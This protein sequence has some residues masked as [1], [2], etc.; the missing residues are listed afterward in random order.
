MTGEPTRNQEPRARVSKAETC[1][2]G[3]LFLTE[4][5]DPAM[6]LLRV[7][8]LQDSPENVG[9][10]RPPPQE[11]HYLAGAGRPEVA[12][13]RSQAGSWT[14]RTLRSGWG[15]PGHPPGHWQTGTSRLWAQAARSQC[16]RGVTEQG[17]LGGPSPRPGPEGPPRPARLLLATAAASVPHVG[18]SKDL[19]VLAV[20]GWRGRLVALGRVHVFSPQGR[21]GTAHHLAVGSGPWEDDV[22]SAFGLEGRTGGVTVRGTRPAP[23]GRMHTCSASCRALSASSLLVPSAPLQPGPSGTW[24]DNCGK[25]GLTSSPQLFCL[26]GREPGLRSNGACPVQVP[27]VFQG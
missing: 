20:L 1:L 4:E 25:T 23:P 10:D 24:V 7:L 21:V 15:L 18:I 9:A 14:P 8:E 19:R 16:G 27:S 22:V 17:G 5:Q 13:A 3:T 2:L 6:S 26:W 11:E 12:L